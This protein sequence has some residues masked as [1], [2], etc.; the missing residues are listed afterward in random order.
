MSL[1]TSLVNI[2][3]TTSLAKAGGP[4]RENTWQSRMTRR[5]FVAAST[6]ASAY[7][8]T[9]TSPASMYGNDIEVESKSH[10]PLNEHA[11]K[12][13]S[14]SNE[15]ISNL[16]TALESNNPSDLKLV[17]DASIHW[18]N[19]CSSFRISDS[20]GIN[21][22]ENRL[23]VLEAGLKNPNI[24]SWVIHETIYTAGKYA[25]FLNSPNNKEISQQT[26]QKKNELFKV[27]SDY[28]NRNTAPSDVV[29][30]TLAQLAN[31][32]SIN[33]IS[34]SF[35][36]STSLASREKLLEIFAFS[37]INPLI[38]LPD[39]LL[40]EI[41]KDLNKTL[42]GHKNTF[43][44]ASATKSNQT[45]TENNNA[46]LLSNR[47][48]LH[49]AK[50]LLILSRNDSNLE[51]FNQLINKYFQSKHP[52]SHDSDYDYI[53]LK[54]LIE[55]INKNP[56]NQNLSESLH[57]L[58]LT[59]PKIFFDSYL[60]ANATSLNSTQ[61]EA[62][63][64][65]VKLFNT[66]Q[67]FG[68]NLLIEAFNSKNASN[69][70]RKLKAIQ[71]IA[72]VNC[73]AKEPDFIKILRTTAMDKN[74]SQ[75]NRISAMRGL[76]RIKD[77]SSIEPLLEIS[78]NES[79]PEFLRGE[80]LYAALLIDTPDFIPKEFEEFANNDRP[81]GL[82]LSY[83]S[84]DI[85]GDGRILPLTI[86]P[87]KLKTSK[88]EDQIIPRLADS[89]DQKYG[90]KIGKFESLEKSKRERYFIP[91]INYL[92]SRGKEKPIDFDIA[93]P[94]LYALSH[95]G[96]GSETLAKIIINPW[97]YVENSNPNQI[98]SDASQDNANELLLK[99]LSIQAL[100]GAIDISNPVDPGLKVL[101]CL[102][103]DDP[104]F[105]FQME[106]LTSAFQISHR[107]ENLTN[108]TQFQEAR[109]EHIRELL[110]YFK[111]D[112]TREFEEPVLVFRDVE[113]KR[114]FACSS[115]V[116]L[117]AS[118]E[119]ID[120]AYE[121]GWNR[122]DNENL[123]VI[124]YAMKANGIKTLDIN[125]LN[126]EDSRKSEFE[127]LFDYITNDRAFFGTL[128]EDH[129]LDGEGVEI[130]VIDGGIPMFFS[131][132]RGNNNFAYDKNIFGPSTFDLKSKHA[133]TVTEQ[134][135][136]K[137]PKVKIHPYTW[138]KVTS[139]QDPLL[140]N[141]RYDPAVQAFEDL[142]K[143]KILGQNNVSIIDM[144][145]G[146]KSPG[147]SNN[148]SYIDYVNRRASMGHLANDLGFG[149]NVSVGNDR[150]VNPATSRN[151]GY[152]E[153][154][155]L[156]S[157]V[158]HKKQIVQPSGVF[159][160]A[161]FDSDTNKFVRTS[162]T[163]NSLHETEVDF[164]GI[165]GVTLANYRRRGIEEWEIYPATSFAVPNK[166]VLDAMVQ[167]KLQRTGQ[168]FDIVK[169]NKIISDTSD[170]HPYRKRYEGW[171][172]ANAQKVFNEYGF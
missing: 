90:G 134:I 33:E 54:A 3:S 22:D 42:D 47:E 150:G 12:V 117:G 75:E 127:S 13:I 113:K 141:E 2:F 17:P 137:L 155:A 156:M 16:K 128:I 53:A 51:V 101:S 132:E 162:G 151:L 4:V 6:I 81:F 58:V 97:N 63:K 38:D 94:A 21:L 106:A 104:S 56:K 92:E 119:L 36:T 120:F 171:R 122:K 67:G 152:G 35:I 126:L 130:A 112:T 138:D 62:G 19:L 170:K 14:F 165:H 45:E 77:D 142:I 25:E 10:K 161:S 40:S 163:Q 69:P 139:S 115:L 83:F 159:R 121:Q 60:C 111:D 148:S 164:I 125:K 7:G 96:M 11:Q 154:N 172:S 39:D 85:D 80:A 8:M 61:S 9:L 74:E 82:E 88:P 109:Q 124:V 20:T 66:N 89:L 131:N 108:K 98:F 114:F 144:S 68:K 32:D 59:H 87:L 71:A 84:P 116:K 24:P 65:I 1:R 15:S 27:I 44:L 18:N 26:I 78:T 102:I 28:L 86:K 41:Q 31:Q 43:L 145:F 48:R 34:K 107:Y 158:N 55:A 72:S 91:L 23:L 110:N 5:S 64:E 143:G 166:G 50:E 95:A 52:E 160:V 146:L 149:C 49:S 37:H 99:V 79:I 129:K 135:I 140:S 93:I 136:R 133:R 118:K 153:V 103:Q 100:G 30:Y 123:R 147:M 167:Q 70:E 168:K 169:Q 57:N 73:L 46:I 105:L 157:A 76:G 29:G